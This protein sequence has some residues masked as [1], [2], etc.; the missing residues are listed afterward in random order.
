VTPSTTSLAVGV[1]GHRTY[2][3]ADDVAARVALV[4]VELASRAA[5]GRLE[6]W[7]SL[8]EG[9]DRV[10][11]EAVIARGGVLRVVLPLPASDY[12]TD[13]DSDRSCAQFDRLLAAAADVRVAVSREPSREAAYE[14][15]GL[16]V[17]EA[18]DVLVAVWDGE[19]SR[20]RGGTADVVAS[21]RARGREVIVVPVRRGIV[22]G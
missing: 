2:H 21:A 8:A 17:V 20:G 4:A 19:P 22:G 18:A 5:G 1:T 11:A 3:D 7:S 16:A 10:V 6:V 12:R 15:A 9:A 14:A 13:F